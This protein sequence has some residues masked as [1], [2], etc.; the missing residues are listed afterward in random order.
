MRPKLWAI[1]ALTL[2]AG[3]CG[4]RASNSTTVSATAL[5][6]DRAGP[7]HAEEQAADG[8]AAALLERLLPDLDGFPTM[9]AL[10][11]LGTITLPGDV[12]E[13]TA[14]FEWLPSEVGGHAR[15]PQLDR[16]SAERS[17]VG[18]G[19]DR[20]TGEVR[21]ALLQV[22]AID[23]TKGD[24]FPTNWTGGQVVAIMARQG[25]EVAELG[26][27]GSLVWIRQ[28]TFMGDAGSTERFPVYSI[29]W[30]RT[31]SPWM[32]TVG[33]D[34]RESREALLAAFVAAAKS[35]RQ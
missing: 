21:T 8:S 15:T 22:Q 20:R 3:G 31:D 1:V 26:R 19:E 27:D 25:E 32:F 17:F 10:G 12:S 18:Y 29:S 24:F 13:V 28:D 4:V 9:P 35:L 33:A 5:A 11:E 2:T 34:T 16:T 7:V 30:G 6:H 14:L 23:L